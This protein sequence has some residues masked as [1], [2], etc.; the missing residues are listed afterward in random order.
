MN[1]ALRII[2]NN[3]TAISM[4]N[5]KGSNSTLLLLKGVTPQQFRAL[6]TL[7]KKSNPGFFDTITGH[8]DLDGYKLDCKPFEFREGDALYLFKYM[9]VI[10]VSVPAGMALLFAF[11]A[12]FWYTI[13]DS[14]VTI[15]R[16]NPNP[17][18]ELKNGE[19]V[20]KTK[21]PLSR[22]VPYGYSQSL[23]RKFLFYRELE[24]AKNHKL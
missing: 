8:Y 9:G 6:Q 22:T 21:I 7:K 16:S 12:L 10:I 19:D 17:F 5:K 3:K 23:D 2:S 14:Q 20:H 1:R 18:L 13:A 15:L 11:F 24:A 4:F